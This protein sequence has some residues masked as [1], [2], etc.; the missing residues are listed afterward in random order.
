MTDEFEQTGRSRILSLIREEFNFPVV[1]EVKQVWPHDGSE[2]R[3][4][5]HEVDVGVPPGPNPETTY[6]RVPV[7][8][9]TSGFVATPRKSDKVLLV[10][11]G[12]GGEKPVVS[13]VVYGDA[14]ADRAPKAAKDVVRAKRG[15][16]Y[17]ELEGDGSAAR[18]AKKPDDTKEPTARVE[19]ADDD[20]VTI[21]T[22]GDVVVRGTSSV[23]IDQGGTSK[24]VLTE[25]A[26]F[27][28]ED[29]GDTGDGSAGTTTKTTT[30]VSN[31]EKTKTQVE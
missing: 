18:L 1:G 29:T 12:G 14:D 6:R 17:A 11:R 30:T 15:S 28:Y 5:N 4:S 24:S 13:Q 20:T 21:E 19:V 10:F 27:E 26:V 23:T 7:G 3:P 25:D 16:L 9:P 22:S 8:V 31:G 2:D